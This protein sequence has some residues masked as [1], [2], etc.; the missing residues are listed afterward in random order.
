LWAYGDSAGDAELL[1]MAD[2]AVRVDRVVIDA[3][4]AEVGPS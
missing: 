1:A 3:V 2:H 4:P